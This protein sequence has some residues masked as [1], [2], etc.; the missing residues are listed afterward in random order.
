MDGFMHVS[1]HRSVKG[2]QNPLI[3][4]IGDPKEPE[5]QHS[6]D[7]PLQLIPRRRVVPQPMPRVLP[8]PH[9]RRPREEETSFTRKQ[10]FDGP[11]KQTDKQKMPQKGRIR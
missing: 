7:R 5:F 9:K 8:R 1:S 4:Y 6:W 11:E 10:S 3:S 2:Y